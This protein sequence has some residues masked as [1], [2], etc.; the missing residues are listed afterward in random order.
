MCEK[1]RRIVIEFLRVTVPR[2]AAP[3]CCSLLLLLTAAPMADVPLS[4]AP[5]A[6]APMAA[7]S[8]L[9]PVAVAPVAVT[10]MA[11][12]PMAGAPVA[13]ALASAAPIADDSLVALVAVAS[14]AAVTMAA[15]PA[16]A[17]L[18][19]AATLNVNKRRSSPPESVIY[20]TNS[21]SCQNGAGCRA[22][23]GCH[24]MLSV[25]SFVV[26]PDSDWLLQKKI[27]THPISK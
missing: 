8:V 6:A 16:D 11:A 21:N 12:A 15:A 3:Y 26:A 25:F 23:I 19:V 24:R 22:L 18:V 5:V 14:V 2:A 7:A 27:K 4:A 9:A 10:P 17:V 13:S 20:W 1:K